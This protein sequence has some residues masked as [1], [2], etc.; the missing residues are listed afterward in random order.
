MGRQPIIVKPIHMLRCFCLIALF[1]CPGFVFPQTLA[2]EKGRAIY[3]SNCAFCHGITGLGGR[4][5]DLVGGTKKTDTELRRIIRDGVP[6]TS[7]PA[8]KSLAP[9]ETVQ[10]VGFLNHLRGSGVGVQK[11][12]GDPANGRKMYVRHGCSGCHQIGTEGSVYGPELT[13]IG[14]ARSVKYL[15]ESIAEPSADIPDQYRGV[16]VI[17]KDGGKIVGARVNEDSFTVQLRLPSQEFRSFIKDEVRQVDHMTESLMPGYKGMPK[18]ILNDIVAY[19]STL[20]G[21]TRQGADV[22][23]VEGIR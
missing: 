17:T 20:K 21:Q 10:V 1:C 14:G 7:M 23:K 18:N 11:A 16:T 6:G 2:V 19:L 4:G 5:P 15:E 8:F 12:T 22:K 9:E 13:R 3:R